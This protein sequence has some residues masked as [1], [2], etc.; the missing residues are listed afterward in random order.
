MLNMVWKSIQFSDS[1]WIH[2]ILHIF[3]ILMIYIC[4][5]MCTNVYWSWIFCHGR[6]RPFRPVLF[7]SLLLFRLWWKKSQALFKFILRNI[8]LLPKTN[9][10]ISI[11]GF[12]S[13][14]LQA[15]HPSTFNVFVVFRS[16]RLSNEWV[17]LLSQK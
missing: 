4:M 11:H 14:S 7:V 8:Y 2:C 9:F 5:C 13:L 10:Y 6:C 15:F 16:V 17:S 12:F 3:D 1:I